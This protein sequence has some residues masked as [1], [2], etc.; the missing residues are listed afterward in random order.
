V[1]A[2][3]LIVAL[4]G[5][6][7]GV[8]AAFAAHRPARSSPPS[9]AQATWSDVPAPTF[10][11]RDQTGK[12]ISPATLAGRPF[13]LTFLDSR[14]RG[15]CPIEGRELALLERQVH[16]PVVVVTADPWRDTATS[17]NSFARRERWSFPWHWLLGT[18]AEVAPVWRSYDVSV[19]RTPT[20]IPHTM[21]LYLVDAKGRQRAAY[22]FPF[23]PAELASDL[24]KLT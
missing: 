18:P 1:K 2:A 11:L 16:L 23:E 17:A 12:E 13:L 6:A 22:L 15:E 24:R 8:A 3:V 20:D 4:T 21:A 14:C 7:L 10:R 9:Y 5:S 19:K